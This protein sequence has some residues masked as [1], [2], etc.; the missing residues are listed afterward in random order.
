MAHTWDHCPCFP[1]FWGAPAVLLTWHHPCYSP[2]VLRTPQ[3]SPS[4]ILALHTPTP[5]GSLP[6]LLE[7]TTPPPGQ[8]VLPG[9]SPCPGPRVLPAPTRCLP[10]LGSPPLVTGP[11]SDHSRAVS[12]FSQGSQDPEKSL[13][14][15]PGWPEGDQLG[16][17]SPEIGSRRRDDRAELFFG[18]SKR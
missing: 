16:T 13:V 7:A 10:Q 14:S 8:Q 11:E 9:V 6:A 4:Q 18:Q 3:P 1:P 15:G 2:W 5:C 17:L 12:S